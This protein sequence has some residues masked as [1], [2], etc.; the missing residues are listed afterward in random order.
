MEGYLWIRGWPLFTE[1]AIC[2]QV[3][4]ALFR[5]FLRMNTMDVQGEIAVV[6]R[7]LLFFFT[8]MSYFSFM[9]DLLSLSPSCDG[10]RHVGI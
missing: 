7:G 4:E 9:I 10:P 8:L 2:R 6:H 3:R 5:M 1:C